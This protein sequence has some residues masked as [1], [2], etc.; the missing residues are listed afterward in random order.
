M[1]APFC[2]L[3]RFLSAFV[4]P[5]AFVVALGWFL[6]VLQ[7]SGID[8]GASGVDFGGFLKGPGTVFGVPGVNFSALLR[9]C[10]LVLGKSFQCVKTIVFPRFL[11]VFHI[12]RAL[13][14]YKKTTQYR[15]KSLS[16]SA[17]HQD[18][19]TNSSWGSPDSI[20][21]G[22]GAMLGASWTSLG[23]LWGALGRLLA[24][25]GRSL[26]ASWTLLGRSW[27]SLGRPGMDLGH[28]LAPGSAPGLDFRGFRGCV[29]LGFGGLEGHVSAFIFIRL[30]CCCTML[31]FAQ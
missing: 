12:S 23:Q 11:Q 8:F 10:T 5:A 25:L 19:A 14:A 18:R 3:G 29:G 4:L 24:P 16:N 21:E 31:L 30:D 7:R 1:L 28:I 27:A 2:A 6:R 26:G 17:S 22:S 15:S 20:L 13:C 9:A